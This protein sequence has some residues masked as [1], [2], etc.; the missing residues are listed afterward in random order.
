M[1][2]KTDE[3]NFFFTFCWLRSLSHLAQGKVCL[4]F[5]K[6][7]LLK[8]NIGEKSAAKRLLSC[9]QEAKLNQWLSRFIWVING[10][11]GSVTLRSFKYVEVPVTRCSWRLQGTYHKLNAHD[12]NQTR[13]SLK[14]G[15]RFHQRRLQA[16]QWLKTRPATLWGTRFDLAVC[17]TAAS[18]RLLSQYWN[19]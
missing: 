15:R 2:E 10:R 12:N 13:T 17:C 16:G 9:V 19:N 6:V 7:D 1:S 3:F 18:R 5:T 8:D 11:G 4:I 14:R